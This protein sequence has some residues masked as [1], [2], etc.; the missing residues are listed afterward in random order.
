MTDLSLIEQ[1]AHEHFVLAG[2]T[3]RRQGY[4]IR[5]LE[6]LERF[7]APKP[8]SD[9]TADDLR[10]WQAQMLRD[11][12]SPSSVR[13]WLNM[14]RPFYRWLWQRESIDPDRFMRIREVK[15]PRGAKPNAVPNPYKRA[16]LAQMWQELD[17]AFPLLADDYYIRRWRK[18]TSP[19]RRVKKHA[20]R[21]QLNAIIELALVCGL[22]RNEI[23]VLS[24][25]DVHP[26][27]KYVVVTGKRTDP[28][29]KKRE[30]PYPDSAREAVRAWLRFRA[31]MGA[32]GPK[33]W[34]SVT[35]PDPTNPMNFG[36]FAAIMHSFGDWRLHRLRHT[37]ATERLRA[38]MPIQNLRR[39]LGHA[40]IT[41]TLAYAEL[42]S[43]D[44]HK[45]AERTEAAF[46]RSLGR[47][48]AA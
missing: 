6:H 21:L 13:T 4:V 1:Y 3:P 45:S 24:I 39:F 19:F 32:T 43:D 7:I 41:Q 29:E 9:V 47:K 16:E 14:V 11:G 38:G 8:I 23:Y 48:E 40:S 33:V 5:R 15:A 36:R 44:I 31:L 37:C 12:A 10:S 25:D 2:V 46:Q 18:G 35:G 42:V 20:M 27:N 26:D 34:L 30:V 28:N 17:R 22:R